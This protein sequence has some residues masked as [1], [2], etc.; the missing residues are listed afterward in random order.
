MLNNTF[1]KVFRTSNPSFLLLPQGDFD[2]KPYVSGDADCL[3]TQ[4][5]GDEDYLLL[6][7]DGFFDVVKPSEVPHLVLDAL[8]QAGEPKAGGDTPLEPS[9]D[10]LGLV[11]QQLVAEAKA[12]GSSDNITVML[13]FLRPPE[14][15]LAEDCTTVTADVPQGSTSQDAPEQ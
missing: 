8:R 1:C 11:A 5:L 15:L 7:C 13:V 4:L 9:E 6:A 3:T 14:Q 12:A 2:Q 10:A